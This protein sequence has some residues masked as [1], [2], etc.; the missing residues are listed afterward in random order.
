MDDIITWEIILDLTKAIESVYPAFKRERKDS[1][2]SLVK[3]LSACYT[4]REDE[5]DYFILR[6]EDIEKLG[7]NLRTVNK[8]LERYPLLIW[9]GNK[10]SSFTKQAKR[11]YAT[12]SFEKVMEA[13]N[14]LVNPPVMV[15]YRSESSRSGAYVLLSKAPAQPHRHNIVRNYEAHVNLRGLQNYIRSNSEKFDTNQ[16]IVL[17]R[18]LAIAKEKKGM[19]TQEYF[20][21]ES[22]R[23]FSR[24]IESVQ[25]MPR[26]IRKAA[27]KGFYDVDFVNAHYRIAAHFTDDPA[28]NEYAYSAKVIRYM[29]SSD[30]DISEDYVKAGFLMLLYGAGTSLRK[31]SSLVEML[32]KDKAKE[33]LEHPRTRVLM[34]GIDKLKTDLFEQCLIEDNSCETVDKLMAKFLM[35]CESEILDVCVKHVTPEA[36]F[37]D[38]F[39]TQQSVDITFLEGKIYEELGINIK[40]SVETI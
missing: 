38:G 35:K 13:F 34:Q 12:E 18:L 19:L 33:F 14:N 2:L 11:Y 28:I 6:K 24:G 8:M 23:L 22:G 1:K 39:I 36:L 17:E 4:V 16:K 25:N 15:Y 31:G 10:Y 20:R 21:G 9:T 7:T 3:A 5:T 27:F 40:L 29:V 32:G 37:F 30:L 26:D